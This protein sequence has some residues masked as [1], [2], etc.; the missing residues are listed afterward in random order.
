ML[1]FNVSCVQKKNPQKQASHYNIVVS[2][3]PQKYI[4]KNLLPEAD[5][6]T[7]I[8]PGMSPETYEPTPSQMIRMSR[9][10]LF[11]SFHLF[12]FEKIWSE[13]IKKQQL[14]IKNIN[15]SNQL[16]LIKEGDFADPHVWTS[17]ILMKIMAETIKNVL[18]DTYPEVSS[19]IEKNFKQLIQKI[20][21]IHQEITTKLSTHADKSFLIYHPA[22]TYY[23]NTYQLH[24]I[25]IEEEGKK[26]SVRSFKQTIDKVKKEKI[27]GIFI[28]Q[29]FD[30]ELAKTISQE[31]NIKVI[32]INP[33]SEDWDNE[34]LEITNKLITQ[35]FN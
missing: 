18:I 15:L 14:S 32:S 3:L 7:L 2:L 28:Q 6:L 13:K 29:Q 4:V 27:N 9:S 11:F 34:L 12:N 19:K 1:I 17:P 5:I 10:D 22:L 16:P 21:K 26:S 25:A 24:Q 8:P 33:L 20:D 35:V 30:K 31:L 23:A